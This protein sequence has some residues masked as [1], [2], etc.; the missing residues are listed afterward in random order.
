MSVDTNYGFLVGT[1]ALTLLEQ[2]QHIRSAGECNSNGGI[3]LQLQLSNID[4]GMLIHLMYLWPKHSGSS[5]YPIP[6]T[7]KGLTPRGCY[8]FHER[9]HSMWTN[10]NAYSKLR[11]ELLD[12]LIAELSKDVA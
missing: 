12:F 4:R 10:R 8:L 9:K 3:C 5:N 7:K 11:Y 2:L 1:L 6:S